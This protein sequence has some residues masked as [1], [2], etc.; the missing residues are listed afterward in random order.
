MAAP[1]RFA[2]MPDFFPCTAGAVH[3]CTFDTV[4]NRILQA[5]DLQRTFIRT[6]SALTSSIDLK[7]HLP[8]FYRLTNQFHRSILDTF[9]TVSTHL[10]H[11][12]ASHVAVAKSASAPIKAPFERYDVAS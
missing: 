2:E 1:E 11:R 4:E 8:G 10:G 5:G 7:I 9:S 3:T 6:A 12:P